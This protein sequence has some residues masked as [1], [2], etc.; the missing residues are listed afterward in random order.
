MTSLQFIVILAGL[1][2]GYKL[3]SYMLSPGSG[4]QTR[5]TTPPP[6]PDDPVEEEQDPSLSQGWREGAAK[7]QSHPPRTWYQTLGIDPSASRQEID[8]AYRRQIS[9]YHPDKVAMM[10]DEI[11]FVAESRTKEINA[12][13]DT[14]TRQQPS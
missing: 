10:G 4:E 11:R 3:I 14:A 13:Y 6:T 5:R 9:Q 12:A 2:I 7:Q 8:C 1:F